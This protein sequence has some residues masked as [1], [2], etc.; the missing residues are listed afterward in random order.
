MRAERWCVSERD[1]LVQPHHCFLLPSHH[2]YVNSARRDVG[3]RPR[4]GLGMAGSKTRHDARHTKVRTTRVNTEQ[5]ITCGVDPHTP[6]YHITLAQLYRLERGRCEADGGRDG[7]ALT[8]W[9]RPT[10]LMAS[11]RPLALLPVALRGKSHCCAASVLSWSWWG[12]TQW[13][14][15]RTISGDDWILHGHQRDGAQEVPQ[16]WSSHRCRGH[17]H[18]SAWQGTRHRQLFGRMK[19]TTFRF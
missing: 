6:L 8:A 16:E 19:F 17:Q 12:T 5:P 7:H 9:M 14:G 2:M 13:K 1:V 18:Q 4:G 15:I 10:R 11:I 3:D